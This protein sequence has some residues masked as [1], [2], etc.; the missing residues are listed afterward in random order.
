MIH[1]QVALQDILD[2][3]AFVNRAINRTGLVLGADERDELEAEGLRIMLELAAAWDGAGTFRGYAAAYLGR[4]LL[5]AW[6][7]MHPGEHVRRRVPGGGR[8]WEYR[9]PVVSFEQLVAA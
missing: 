7:Q 5:S 2:V 8:R 4:R 3:D 9:P 6:H 1:T